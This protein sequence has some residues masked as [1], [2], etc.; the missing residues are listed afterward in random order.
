MW[1]VDA[2]RGTLVGAA[3]EAKSIIMGRI[4]PGDYFSRFITTT[5]NAVTLLFF[6][7]IE[8]TPGT[9]LNMPMQSV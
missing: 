2:S 8:L 5:L 7:G 9:R 6:G 3:P 4:D 1:L